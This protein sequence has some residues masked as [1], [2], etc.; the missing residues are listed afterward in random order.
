M[1]KKL[2]RLSSW[3]KWK[4]GEK[5][6]IDQLDFQGMF[7]IPMD[8]IRIPKGSII[9]CPHWQYTVKCSSVRQSSMCCNGLKKAVLQLHAVASTWSFYVELPIQQLFLGR[10]SRAKKYDFSKSFF[11]VKK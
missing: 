5:K 10:V 1:R 8:P 7:G 9:L 3:D 11:F 2:K 4:A 6:Q